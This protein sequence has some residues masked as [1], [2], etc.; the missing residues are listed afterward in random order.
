MSSDDGEEPAWGYVCEG[1]QTREAR[2]GSTVPVDKRRGGLNTEGTAE[3][4]ATIHR[5]KTG[6][7]P[8]VRKGLEA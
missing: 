8:E 6:H 5:V 1:C 2:D 3:T 7:D 4:L